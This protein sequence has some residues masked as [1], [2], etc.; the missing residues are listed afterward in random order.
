MHELRRNSE[1]QK[2]IKSLADVVLTEAKQ[3]NPGSIQVDATSNTGNSTMT[4]SGQITGIDK[5]GGTTT[6]NAALNLETTALSN[7]CDSVGQKISYNYVVKNTGNVP[8]T[9][10]T[11]KD[12]KLGIVSTLSATLEP[13]QIVSAVGIY[14]ITQADFD[15]GYVTNTANAKG[16][17]KAN[18][19][20]SNAAIT[21]VT[22]DKP[23]M[24][25]EE[26]AL[27]ATYDVA[28]Q[29]ITYTYKVTNSGNVK[30]SGPIT[31]TDNRNNKGVPFVISQNDLAVGDQVTFTKSYSVNDDDLNS[32]SVTNTAYA[33]GGY[34]NK[35]VKSNDAT[36]TI[37]AYKS[38]LAI[39]ESASQ[40]NY[41]EEGQK[42]AFNY[43]VK[44]TGNV[45]IT[46]L[47]VTDNKLGTV[48]VSSTTLEPKNSI[49]VLAT[50]TITEADIKA[51]SVTSLADA[52]GTYNGKE[53]RSNTDTV[54]IKAD[55]QIP[56][57]PS[58]VLPVLAIF[59]L[60]LFSH[61]RKR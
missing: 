36:S 37:T 45:P 2:I 9:G 25:L 61:R 52:T 22:A 56:E 47:K 12:D 53:I 6:E 15:A 50:Y 42:I 28:G 48:A 4:S 18:K 46:G 55:T 34:N 51:G 16:T 11:I 40:T 30:I 26:S 44:N 24:R 20:Q 43:L 41:S 14:T 17:Y 13:G 35:Q 33:T 32:D 49:T 29:T 3:V 60:I 10:L 19:I 39:S 57:F 23:S 7:T 31:V 59:G 21:T 27:P 1:D 38:A 58:I 5:T 54:K 8:I